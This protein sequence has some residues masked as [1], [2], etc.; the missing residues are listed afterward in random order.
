MLLR[1][2]DQAKGLCNVTRL[3]VNH[4]GKNVIS[5]IVITRKN[6]GGRIFIPRMDLV[7]SDSRLPSKFQRRQFP[8]SL[9]FGMKINK[10]QGQTLSN[11]LMLQFLE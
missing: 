4:L 9:C 8:I 11:I 2:I 3:Q 5:T 1:N 7:S 6:I 10:S